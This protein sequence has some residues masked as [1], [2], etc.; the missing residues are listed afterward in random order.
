M[1]AAVAAAVGMT[2]AGLVDGLDHRTEL[3]G[4]QRPAAGAEERV[5]EAFEVTGPWRQG[6]SVE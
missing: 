1:S 3:Q 5:V 2:A 6:A 4:R